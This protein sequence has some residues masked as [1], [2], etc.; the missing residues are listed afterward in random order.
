MA[1]LHAAASLGHP[2][3][4][5]LLDVFETE[6]Q[7]QLVFELLDGGSL[8]DLVAAEQQRH[9]RPLPEARAREIIKQVSSALKALHAVGICHRDLKLQN[10]ML[11]S[12]GAAKICDFGFATQARAGRSTRGATNETTPD[13]RPGRQPPQPAFQEYFLASL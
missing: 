4:V 9:R 2:N 1:I 13:R 11:D 10:V 8:L 7:V 3:I 5:N 12:A 6:D